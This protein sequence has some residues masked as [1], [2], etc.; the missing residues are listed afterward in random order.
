MATGGRKNPGAKFFE[1]AVMI[2]EIHW[3]SDSPKITVA[4]SNHAYGLRR[5]LLAMHCLQGHS[6]CS[7]D[8]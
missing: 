3:T 6:N 2:F 8:N 1:K 7:D 5:A 4:L